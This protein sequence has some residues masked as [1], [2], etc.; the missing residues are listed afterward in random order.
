MKNTQKLREDINT[1]VIPFLTPYAVF[2]VV[3]IESLP[4]RYYTL[5]TN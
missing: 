2:N 1:R 3:P 5:P 4:D